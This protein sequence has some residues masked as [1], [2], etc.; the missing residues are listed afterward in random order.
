MNTKSIISKKTKKNTKKN[1]NSKIRF[2]TL[3]IYETT[4]FFKTFFVGKNTWKF[5]T[6]ST[7]TQTKNRK[8]DFSLVLAHCACFMQIGTFLR[9]GR[10]E[11][12]HILP[13]D[14]ASFEKIRL[15]LKPPPLNSIAQVYKIF[16][17][18]QK[19]IT[20]FTNLLYLFNKKKTEKQ[21]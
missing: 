17:I 11:G 16:P 5:W 10:G 9:R 15:L 19:K 21:S 7:I 2:R 6:K 12:L 8:I 1:N 3:C 4:F 20:E 14:R 13:R 18:F